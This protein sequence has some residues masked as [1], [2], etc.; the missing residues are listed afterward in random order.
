MAATW[1]NSCF[2][3]SKK[4]F[5]SFRTGKQYLQVSSTVSDNLFNF[6]LGILASK[7]PLIIGIQLQLTIKLSS[8]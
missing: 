7:N 4:E 6:G 5:I 3:I 8:L 2:T 1:N